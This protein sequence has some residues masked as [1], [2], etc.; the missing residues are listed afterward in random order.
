MAYK[1]AYCTTCSRSVLAVRNETNHVL[2]LLLTLVTC[3]LWFIVWVMVAGFSDAS[4]RCPEC[5]SVVNP[6]RKVA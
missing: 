5:G 4:F 6:R 3:G 1:Q 2:H